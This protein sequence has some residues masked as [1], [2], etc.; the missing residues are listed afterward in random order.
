M[1]FKALLL[2]LA[3]LS[4]S[5]HTS[6]SANEAVQDTTITPSIVGGVTAEDGPYRWTISLQS[7]SGSPF[8]GGSLVAPDWILTASHCVEGSPASSLRV[9]IGRNNLNSSQGEV[10]SISHVIMHPNYSAASTGYDVALLRLSNPANIQ[11][12]NLADSSVMARVGNADDTARVLG[13][14][15]TR[16]G[17][18]MTNQ[19]LRVDVPIVSQASCRNSYGSNIDSTMICAGYTSGG[20][21]S[22]QGDSGGP[23]VLNLNGTYYQAGV[24]SW[25]SGCAQPNYPGVYARV[26]AMLGWISSYIDSEGGE[27]FKETNLSAS[28]DNWLYYTIDVSAGASSLIVNASSGSGDADLYVRYGNQPTSNSYDCRPYISGNDE[29][30]SFSN[31]QAGTWHIG[32]KGY[33]S[34]SGVTLEG[35]VF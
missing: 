1:K 3:G 2:G 15:A 27:S 32:L 21:D 18:S 10:H 12:V 24:V 25:G 31:P 33:S 30:C 20:K 26:E 4:L 9:V 22:C 6:L 28:K 11:P 8:C 16:Q 19:L 29:S 34:F 13:W 17:G 5:T 23:L 7:S 35:A 14:G